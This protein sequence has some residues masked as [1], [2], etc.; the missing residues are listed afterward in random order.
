MSSGSGIPK[1]PLASFLAMQAEIEAAPDTKAGSSV[2]PCPPPEKPKKPPVTVKIQ[3]VPKAVLVLAPSGQA[4]PNVLLHA[5]HATPSGG[6]FAWTAQA[7]G[8]VSIEGRSTKA[9]FR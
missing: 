4:A 5:V 6:E 3:E 8:K 1:S 7:G 9:F 2:Q